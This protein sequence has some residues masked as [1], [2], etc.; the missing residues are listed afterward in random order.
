MGDS[1][2]DLGLG[3]VLGQVM[4]MTWPGLLAYCVHDN[5]SRIT[6]IL[7]QDVALSKMAISF[8]LPFSRPGNWDLHRVQGGLCHDKTHTR[9]RGYSVVARMQ[10]AALWVP[11]GVAQLC[12]GVVSG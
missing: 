2:W 7:A 6:S 3:L 1:G 8:S 10:S 5:K 4:T 9:Y 12:R 11:R